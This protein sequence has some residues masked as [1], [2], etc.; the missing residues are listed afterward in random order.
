MATRA[1]KFASCWNNAA[2]WHSGLISLCS[3]FALPFSPWAVVWCYLAIIFLF[4]ELLHRD[5]SPG[6]M[7]RALADPRFVHV[8]AGASRLTDASGRGVVR[9]DLGLFSAPL[10]SLAR[11]RR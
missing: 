5:G 7:S 6:W 9:L 1:G 2:W 11:M 10:P 8:R 4:N 3:H